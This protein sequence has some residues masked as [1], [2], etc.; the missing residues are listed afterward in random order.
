VT[1]TESKESANYED[2]WVGKKEAQLKIIK[3]IINS[4]IEKIVLIVGHLE[5]AGVT[6]GFHATCFG[7]H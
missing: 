4:L 2:I 1:N 7:N 3:T 6:L 5:A